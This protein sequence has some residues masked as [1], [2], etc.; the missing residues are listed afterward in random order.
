MGTAALLVQVVTVHVQMFLKGF[1]V[2]V[3]GW[4]IDLLVRRLVLDSLR[5]WVS[6]TDLELSIDVSYMLLPANWSSFFC[7]CDKYNT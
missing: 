4:W 6:T 2:N 5:L 3:I 1:R 7:V